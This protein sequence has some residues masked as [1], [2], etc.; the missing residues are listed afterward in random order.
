MLTD[1]RIPPTGTDEGLRSAARLRRSAHEKVGVV[2]LSQH[3]EGAAY[4]LALFEGGAAGRA[5]LLKE[6]V[7]RPRPAWSGAIRAVASR[8]LRWST[9]KVV[10][11]LVAALRARPRRVAARR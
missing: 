3:D 11:A 8:R 2:V 6:R 10:D 4:A 9:P 5:Y 7:G 1:I